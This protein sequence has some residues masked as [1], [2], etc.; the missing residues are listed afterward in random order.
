MTGSIE[1][2]LGPKGSFALVV[3]RI[4]IH[5]ASAVTAIGL[6]GAF[7]PIAIHEA[8]PSTHDTLEFNP[9]VDAQ[10]PRNHTLS[11]R[12]LFYGVNDTG[13]GVGQFAL[14]SQAFDTRKTQHDVQISDIHVLSV[15]TL[16][17]LRVEFRRSDVDQRPVDGSP[18]IQVRSDT[19]DR[20][21]GTDCVSS[22]RAGSYPP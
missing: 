6:D 2:P 1:G 5:D 21:P 20:R 8:V 15:K 16:N 17:E 9:R 10:L 11:V 14:P 19:R 7:N 22:S 18:Q 4:A 13:S 12:Y 3:D